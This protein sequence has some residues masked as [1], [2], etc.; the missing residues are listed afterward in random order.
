MSRNALW[1]TINTFALASLIAWAMMLSHNAEGREQLI[2]AN[3]A[4]IA[5]QHQIEE[6]LVRIQEQ[7]DRLLEVQVQ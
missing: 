5:E 6:R 3:T 1:N 7:L 4:A 2:D